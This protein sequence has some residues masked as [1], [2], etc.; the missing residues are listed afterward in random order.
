MTYRS[1]PAPV[2]VQVITVER[3]WW[4]PCEFFSFEPKPLKQLRSVVIKSTVF[5]PYTYSGRSCCDCQTRGVWSLDKT[6][7]PKVIASAN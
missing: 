3:T 6:L 4:E 5:T 1:L 7:K 2:S